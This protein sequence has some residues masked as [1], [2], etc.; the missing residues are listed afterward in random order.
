[1]AGDARIAQLTQRGTA[2]TVVAP[3]WHLTLVQELRRQ[4]IDARDSAR[5]VIITLPGVSF[6]VNR[7][8]LSP[9]GERSIRYVPAALLRPAAERPVTVEGHASR[10]KG[11]L[12]EQNQRL[13]DDRAQR[14]AD[15]LLLAGLR[16]DRLTA[17][18]LGSS[19][20]V[21]SNDTEEGRR[22]NRRG[23]VIVAKGGK[24]CR[25]GGG[26]GAGKTRGGKG[27]GG[28]GGPRGGRGGPDR[29]GRAPARG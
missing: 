10:E 9:Q 24:R 8:D 22:L 20:P 27:G 4:G 14:V 18:G 28:G 6:A 5:G 19:T 1:A 21:A 23:G 7:S 25:G 15:T 13:S 17:R 12:D 16:R 11:T 2:P 26:A 29:P 3:E